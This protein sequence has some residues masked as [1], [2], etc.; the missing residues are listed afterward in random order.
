M[1]VALALSNCF[2]GNL[3]TSV[4]L[5]AA[6]FASRPSW[7]PSEEDAVASFLQFP[8]CFVDL[9]YAALS[10]LLLWLVYDLYR[11]LVASKYCD[12]SSHEI[13]RQSTDCHRYRLELGH[14]WVL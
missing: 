7:N 8:T 1:S 5:R 2:C 11:G 14:V 6:F 4:A 3:P 13:R 12:L 10:R 9:D